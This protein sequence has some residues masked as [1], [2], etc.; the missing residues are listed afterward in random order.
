M[1]RQDRSTSV[2]ADLLPLWRQRRLSSRSST[3]AI[4]DDPASVDPSWRAFFARAR[5]RPRERSPRAPAAPSWTQPDWPRRRQRRARLGPRRQLAGGRARRRREAAGQG[6]RPGARRSSRRPTC[7]RRR[8]IR[9]ARMMLIRAYRVRGHLAADLDP[10]GLEPRATIRELDPAYL[11]LHRGRL[12]PADLH[13]R[14]ARA[15]DATVREIARRSC[16]RTYCGHVGVEYMHITDP[17]REG[18]GSRSGSRAPTRRSP[19]PRGQARDPQ[20]ADRGRGL[21]EVP[22]RQVRRHQAL[23]PRRRRSADP[24]AGADDQVRRPARREGD[25]HRHGP[26]RPAQRPRQRDGQALPRDLPRVRGR[27]VAARRTSRARAT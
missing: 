15:R 20:Q 5:G 17:E 22:R 13:R 7:S 16:R 10:L 3:R 4:A 11:R 9:S 19:S 1:A 18:A 23:R 2:R 27:L 21:R 12:R 26:P 14:R 24:G 8:A 6:A 25:R